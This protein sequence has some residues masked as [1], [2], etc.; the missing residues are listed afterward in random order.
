MR[1]VRS[2]GVLVTALILAALPAQGQLASRSPEEWIKT[3]ESPQR[4]QGL[5]ID[6]TIAALG[7]KPGDVVADIGAGTGLF[8]AALAKAVGPTG[9]VYAEDVDQGL[10]DAISKKQREFGI[11][12]IVTVLGGFTDPKLPAKDVD[13]AMIN[14]VL[15]HIEDRATYLKNLAQYLEPSGRIALIDFH[16]EK[17][18]HRTQPELQVSKEQAT[19]WMADA[20]LKPLQEIELFAEKYFVIYEKR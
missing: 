3:L 11:S 2:I 7:L 15:H 1:M 13:L 5:K 18:G 6:E 17:G 14:D 10:I 20:G 12:N 4:I 19:K 9:K 16:P 8:E